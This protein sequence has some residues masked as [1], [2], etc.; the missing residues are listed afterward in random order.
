MVVGQSFLRHDSNALLALQVDIV[1]DAFLN[2]LVG[3]KDAALPKHGP[4]E[5]FPVIDVSN[6][7]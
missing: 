4:R 1:H 7:R 5:W 6:N 2:A 3:T